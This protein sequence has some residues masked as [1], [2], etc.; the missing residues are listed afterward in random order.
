MVAFSIS[1]NW[2]LFLKKTT[3]I[4]SYLIWPYILL[5][6]CGCMNIM[7]YRLRFYYVVTLIW[8]L[9]PLGLSCLTDLDLKGM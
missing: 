9:P 5:C 1:I 7:F 8:L 2:R 3:F 6:Y 4:F